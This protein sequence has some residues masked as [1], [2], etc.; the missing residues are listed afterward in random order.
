MPLSPSSLAGVPASVTEGGRQGAG[1]GGTGAA[2]GGP[3]AASAVGQ[4]A[5]GADEKADGP[6][7]QVGRGDR[8]PHDD[9]G[10][11]DRQ[12]HGQQR[13]AGEGS[14]GG[15]GSDHQ[16][17]DQQGTDDGHG[18][19]GGERDDEQEADLDAVPADPP[20]LCDI[21]DDGGQQERPVDDRD[22]GD[23]GEAQ[24]G[25]GQDLG[26]ADAEDLAEQQGEDLR[27]VLGGPG[28]ERGA[29]GE[30]H[31]QCERGHDVAATASAHEAD[32]EG[33]EDG[34]HGQTEKGADAEQAGPGR[35]GERA[36]GDGVG[37]ER[38]APQ[39]DEIP[40]HAGDDRD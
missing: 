27:L 13:P 4:R 23:A 32:P 35:A 26:G 6:V 11:D 1:A 30:H 19:G 36:L 24:G 12:A 5:E 14:G 33:A 3:A 25:D 17:E 20:G 37:W 39:H 28:Q 8:G 38:R 18:H 10:D 34:E 22:R 21:G 31:D 15:G 7:V 2:P 29:E 16:A 9:Q 40:D